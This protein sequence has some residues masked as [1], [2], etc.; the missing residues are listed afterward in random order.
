MDLDL[1]GESLRHIIIGIIGMILIISGIIF[2]LT[3][4]QVDDNLAIFSWDKETV[5]EDVQRTKDFLQSQKIRRLFQSFASELSMDEIQTFMGRVSDEVDVYQLIGTPEWAYA[6]N[7]AR[8]ID[9]GER[10]VKINN[11]LDVE[12]QIKGLVVDVEP[13]LLDDFDWEDEELKLSFME[14]MKALYDFLQANDLAMITVVPY[15][16]ETKGYKDVLDFLIKEAS[17]EL[18]VMNYFR[19]EEVEHILY[20]TTIAKEVD[21]AVTTIY[22]FKAP[23][24][25]DLTERNT[26]Y[27]EGL[28][29]ALN[30]FQYVKQTFD[31]Q[32]IYA[33]FHDLTALKEVVGRE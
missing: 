4:Q 22:E 32:E 13:Y 30:N 5:T 27:N 33:A 9:Q 19:E 29:K 24:E 31:E 23:G 17:T 1:G 6:E 21:L 16:Y 15:F 10:V 3:T 12:N 26:Y 20:E 11:T 7:K 25:Y 14:N 8:L 18:A 28:D 2:Y